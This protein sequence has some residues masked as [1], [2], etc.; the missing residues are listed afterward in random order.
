[1]TIGYI[2]IYY[3]YVFCC[4]GDTCIPGSDLVQQVDVGNRV[5]DVALEVADLAATSRA[6]QM[7]V[8]PADQDLLWGQLHELLQALSLQQ[9]G[10]QVGVLMQ[11]DVSKKANLDTITHL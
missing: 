5:L 3:T 2:Y 9:Q 4:G 1:M 8:D 10:S 11:V 6:I 7:E